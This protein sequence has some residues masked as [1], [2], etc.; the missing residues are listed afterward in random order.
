VCRWID[1][2][3]EP[4]DRT[5]ALDPLDGTKGY[6]RGGQYAV[7]L[8][9]IDRGQVVLGAL[10]C[11]ALGLAACGST[12]ACQGTVAVAV[13]G[14]G[15]WATPMGSETFVRLCVSSRPAP[16]GARLLRSY[17]ADHTDVAKLDQIAALLGVKEPPVRM[18]SQAKSLLLAAGE[19]ELIF[20]LISPRRPDYVEKVWDQAAGA[21]IVEEAGGRVTDLTG[22][23]LDF[24][25]GRTL[26]HNI[27]VLASNGWL[28]GAALEAVRRAGADR[29]PSE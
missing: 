28:H 22:R 16:E 14:Q 20:R 7:A 8:A 17:E 4:A 3:G 24:A 5:W 23:A 10:A 1:G 29:R 21:L 13:R 2:V 6:L 19:G 26:D 9:L 11:P 27:G 12:A 25:A 15:A 18:D